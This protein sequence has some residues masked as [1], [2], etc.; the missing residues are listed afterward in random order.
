MPSQPD[1]IA[2]AMGLYDECE[3]LTDRMH[4]I[5]SPEIDSMRTA[6]AAM[7]ERCQA[8]LLNLA[9]SL[10]LERILLDEANT[11]WSNTLFSFA[12]THESE[13]FYAL[14]EKLDLG[15]LSRS[16]VGTLRSSISNLG[17][18]T[19]VVR[20]KDQEDVPF[21]M[22]NS[23]FV[24]I[25]TY[26]GLFSIHHEG[27]ANAIW[28]GVCRGKLNEEQ[29]IAAYEELRTHPDFGL[30][31]PHLTSMLKT[32]PIAPLLALRAHVL[33]DTRVHSGEC[34]DRLEYILTRIFNDH[35]IAEDLMVENI[36]ALLGNQG[37]RTHCLQQDLLG[38]L[39]N[40]L[41]HRRNDDHGTFKH[42][43]ALSARLIQLL[44]A[45]KMSD[46][47][48]SMI[49]LQ[50]L[51]FHNIGEAFDAVQKDPFRG[52]KK[53]A[54]S[55][56]FTS[57]NHL[58][59]IDSDFRPCLKKTLLF[60]MSDDAQQAAMDTHDRVKILYYGLTHDARYLQ[61]VQHEAAITT[62]LE[63]DLGL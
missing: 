17:Y 51:H 33:G 25:A 61:D 52:A 50:S 40:E 59:S 58:G 9:D 41:E 46:G 11:Q 36:A 53:L 15:S 45:L 14:L 24:N 55:L 23:K 5:E 35:I 18:L 44:K 16:R 7:S 19:H 4:Q 49:A 2:I 29:S 37:Y 28:Q 1:D 42:G 57:Q 62:V 26:E 13:G 27:L 21:P 22:H 34:S 39:V 12:L 60:A 56:S 32:A 3:S 38:H 20:I 6:I 54:D 10:G 43:Q 30:I 48:L 8:V 47:E 31:H 63:D